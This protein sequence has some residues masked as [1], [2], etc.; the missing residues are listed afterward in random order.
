MSLPLAQGGGRGVDRDQRPPGREPHGAGRVRRDQTERI[1]NCRAQPV[2]ADQRRGLH[3]LVA[4]SQPHAA[5][6]LRKAVAARGGARLDAEAQR[7]VEQ[8]LLQIGAMEDA[9]GRAPAVARLSERQARQNGAVG[10]AAN[11]EGAGLESD[12][13]ER[14]RACRNPAG[15]GRRWA[16]SAGRRRLP[17]FARRAPG[18]A[19][20]CRRGPARSPRRARL[21]RRRRRRRGRPS[22]RR[23]AVGSRT[24]S[25]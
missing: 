13:V 24:V 19:S 17:R 12:G 8:R 9:E 3:S 21:C 2:G 15:C 11:I 10:G 6:V 1:A 16:K 23:Q 25:E 7:L 20:A 5:R 4:H 14:R 22:A 18:R